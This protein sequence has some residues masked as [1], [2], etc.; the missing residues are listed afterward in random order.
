M[1]IKGLTDLEEHIIKKI[2]FPYA[3]EY[4]F[5]Y[6]GSRVKGD[7]E[8]L[9]DLDLLIKGENKFP[10]EELCKIH[11]EFDNSNLPFVV[12]TADYHTIFP[13]FYEIIK[14]D[15]VDVFE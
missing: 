2:L 6:Y 5:Y 13:D 3:R 15:L 1:T 10:I 12:N 14:K 8:P 4:K 9:S 7:F 11:T